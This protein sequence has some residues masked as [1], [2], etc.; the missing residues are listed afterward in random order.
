MVG[1]VLVIRSW[2]ADHHLPYLQYSNEGSNI[3]QSVVV[4]NRGPSAANLQRPTLSVHV[5]SAVDRI[6]LEIGRLRGDYGEDEL[7]APPLMKDLGVGIAEKSTHVVI[8]NRLVCAVMGA[9][10]VLLTFVLTWQVFGQ[11]WLALL[12]AAFASISALL[13]KMSIVVRPEIFLVFF[14][15]LTL[16]GA[17]RV[18]Q[19]GNRADYLLAGVAAGLTI[20]SKYNG[21]L[22]VLAVFAAHLL[23]PREQRSTRWLGLAALGCTLAFLV[24]TPY[25]ILDPGRFLSDVAFEGQHYS[26][27]HLGRDEE[28]W[29]Y[30]LLALLGMEGLIAWAAARLVVGRGPA[31]RNPCV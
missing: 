1:Y 25:A 4:A 8:A 14:V 17:V 22:V 7:L 23:A 12:A 16:V 26:S 6:L 31:G 5:L 11:P 15:T 24:S 27:G 20:G 18:L 29:S 3:L 30:Y 9:G 21:G 2:S 19:R 13:T 10:T 28:G